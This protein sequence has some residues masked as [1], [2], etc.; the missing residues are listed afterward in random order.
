MT[1]NEESI[2][3]LAERFIRMNPEEF[4][5]FWSHV[6]FVWNLESEGEDI[7]MQ[8]FFNGK[9]ASYDVLTVIS[10]MHSAVASGMKS[11]GKK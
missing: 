6:C 4:R 11:E 9:K 1:D 3:D 2:T 7:D 10:A 5:A 8:W